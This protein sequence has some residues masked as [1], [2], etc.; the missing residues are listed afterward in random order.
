MDENE[1]KNLK[2]EEKN[3]AN[4]GDLVNLGYVTH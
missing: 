1:K 3:Q 4:P 2:K